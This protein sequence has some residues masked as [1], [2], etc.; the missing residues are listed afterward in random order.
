[1]ALIFFTIEN[2]HFRLHMFQTA[3]EKPGWIRYI[4]IMNSLWTSLSKLE[5]SCSVKSMSV[6]NSFCSLQL[7]PKHVVQ[8]N[9]NKANCVKSSLLF[10]CAITHIFWYWKEL[11]Q[12]TIRVRACSHEPGTVNYPGASVTSRSHDDLYVAP[13]QV[14]GH[15]ITTKVS[16]FL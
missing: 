14:Q 8:T 16:E 11:S 15:L 6:Q 12:V 5:N 4:S 10:L 3:V 9:R 1:M 2:V 13:G 7:L